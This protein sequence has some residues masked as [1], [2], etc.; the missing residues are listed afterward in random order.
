[1][2]KHECTIIVDTNQFCS[3]L[4]LS[5]LRWKRLIEYINKTDAC[6][7]MPRIVWQEIYRNYIKTVGSYYGGAIST[8]DKLNHHIGF[9]SPA[10][11][12]FGGRYEMRDARYACGDLS[13]DFMKNLARAYLAYI[14]NT[15]QLKAKDFIETDA[16]WFN[17]LVERAINHIKPFS[18]ESD[19][20]FKDTLLWKSI[21]SLGE[22]AGFKDH[23]VILISSNT[24]DF[25]NQ[26]EKGKLH[27]SL[28]REAKIYGLDLY[29]FDNLDAF[30]QNWAAEIINTDFYGIRKVVSEAIIVAALRMPLG[31]WMLR[32]ESLEHNIFFTGTNFKIESP[33]IGEKVIRVSVSGYLTNT[34]TSCEYMDF[35]AE[36]LYREDGKGHQ[37]TV[38]SLVIPIEG[39]LAR[40]WPEL[41]SSDVSSSFLK[42]YGQTD[43]DLP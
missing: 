12:F 42:L 15:L 27:P 16:G 29:Y 11:G 8:I 10:I 14:K 35:N 26:S 32:N 31:R 13:G 3:D 43:S 33:A 28:E 22:R 40:N 17:D 20:G 36:V 18:D 5:G 2:S 4:M 1:M 21:L 37:C 38:E 9:S 6:L 39:S 24:R 19:K 7:Q 25:G 41:G 23:P 30:L 34:N